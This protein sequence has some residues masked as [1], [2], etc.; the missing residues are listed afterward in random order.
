MKKSNSKPYDNIAINLNLKLTAIIVIFLA[1]IVF[2]FALPVTNMSS[3][4]EVADAYGLEDKLNNDF[5]TFYEKKIAG[6][7]VVSNIDK[8]QLLSLQSTHN[9]TE[10]RTVLLLIFEDFG[11]RVDMKKDFDE[12]TKMS[13]KQLVLYGKTLVDAFS[14]DLSESEKN[15]LKAEFFTLIKGKQSSF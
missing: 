13:D 15:N 4:R 8:A 1:V 2:L 12:L 9:L 3:S 14:K 5:V 10:K 6:E 7:P 11:K